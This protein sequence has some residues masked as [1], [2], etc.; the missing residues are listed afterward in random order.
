[1]SIVYI[2]KPADFFV[3]HRVSTVFFEC[4]D[5]L[6]L[7]QRS[8][9]SKIAPGMWCVPGGKFEGEETPLECLVREVNEELNILLDAHQVHFMKSL[10][11][12]HVIMDYE[13]YL[14][15]YKCTT[16]PCIKINPNEHF[17]YVWQPMMHFNELPLLEGQLQAFEFCFPNCVIS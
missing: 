5:H 10:Y 12:R 8:F 2:E 3:R 4:D 7:L 17:T 14:Y 6:L 15:H 1:M 11:V 16:R 9:Q 13:L